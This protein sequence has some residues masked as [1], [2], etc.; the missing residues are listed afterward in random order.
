MLWFE[1]RVRGEHPLA[2]IAR[3]AG[4]LVFINGNGVF[5]HPDVLPVAL[6]PDE[7]FRPLRKALFQSCYYGLPIISIL[8]RLFFIDADD[9]ALS[10]MDDFLYLEVLFDLMVASRSGKICPDL[11]GFS[12]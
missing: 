10:P 3:L 12:S 9:I 8:F 1:E 6:V 7:T 2:V 11:L 4:N 5:P